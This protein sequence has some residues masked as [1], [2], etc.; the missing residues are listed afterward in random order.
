MAKTST[1]KT[2][3]PSKQLLRRLKKL[4]PYFILESDHKVTATKDFASYLEGF[5]FLCRVVVH[6]EVLHQS[7]TVTLKGNTVK[8]TIETSPKQTLGEQEVY[9]AERLTKLLST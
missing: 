5:M 1:K 7:P 6:S 2:P 9:L 3:T 4:E 8:I